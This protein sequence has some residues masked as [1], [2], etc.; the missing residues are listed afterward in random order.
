MRKET[1]AKKIGNVRFEGLPECGFM[2][3]RAELVCPSCGYKFAEVK[4][5][6]DE[7]E[8][9]LKELTDK[10]NGIRGKR[11]SELSES[12]LFLYREF[13]GKKQYC[14]RIARAMGEE[15][16]IN[17]AKLCGYKNGFLRHNEANTNLKFND[18]IIR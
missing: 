3:E 5:E 15:Y 1:A 10:F 4:K 16:L 11:I 12:E 18:L 6:E 7:P 9:V 14:L 13:T 17:F 8:T 2:C